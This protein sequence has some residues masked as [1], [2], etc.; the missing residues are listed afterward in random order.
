ML[1]L[2]QTQPLKS[3]SLSQL[4]WSDTL[5]LK[6]CHIIWSAY[7]FGKSTNRAFDLRY[8][9]YNLS[10]ELSNR[11]IVWFYHWR[12]QLCRPVESLLCCKDWVGHCSYLQT[13]TAIYIET[14]FWQF[15]TYMTWI[16]K[17][18]LPSTFTGTF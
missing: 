11:R 5:N 1:A 6:P 12:N 15:S 10:S 2:P 16:A 3:F 14:R 7:I 17:N 8:Y 4:S 9:D 18:C 13:N